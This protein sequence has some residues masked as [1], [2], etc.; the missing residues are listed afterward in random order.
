MTPEVYDNEIYGH[1]Y[2][3]FII[4]T[5][6]TDVE[7]GKRHWKERNIKL[8]DD[9]IAIANSKRNLTVGFV[10]IRHP[11]GELMKE[12]FDISNFELPC[13]RFVKDGRHYA[14]IFVE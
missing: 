11:E 6:D 9:M 1:N 5:A 10:D 12:T 2:P 3:W 7:V 8:Y 13:I 14:M 4:F